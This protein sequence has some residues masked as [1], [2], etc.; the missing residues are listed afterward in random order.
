MHVDEKFTLVQRN[1]SEI[2]GESDLK[3]LLSMK[4]KPVVYLGTAITGSPHIAY[5][6]W[7]HKLADFARAG[8]SVKL[9]LAD[10]HGALDGTGWDLLEARYAYYSA[11]IPLMFES[12]GV[13]KKSVLFVKG[14]DFELSKKYMFD[15]L[16]LS[17]LVGVHD[18]TKAASEVVKLGDNP[19]LAGI[20]YPLMQALDEEYLGVDV[21]YGGVDQRKIFV[22]AG[23]VLPK[24]GYRKRVHVMTPMLPGLIG[25]KMSAS[26]PASK[27]DLLDDEVTVRKKINAAE[28]VA[29]NP[30]NGLMAFLKHLIFVVKKDRKESF[31]V[32]RKAEHG[33]KLVYA[34]YEDLERDFISQKLHPGDLKAAVA[35]EIISLLE[36]M[37]K[38]RERLLKLRKAAYE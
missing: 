16:K 3:E 15:L 4:K 32:E 24:I 27:I 10:V 26:V 23:E 1:T 6:L 5:F 19:R 37:F 2:I 20:L 38:D 8:F 28:C 12:L 22:L 11:I 31:V 18:A 35:R 17:T 34:S 33:G 13:S 25:S 29:G 14:S 21:Q 36:P 9:L 30:D 7:A